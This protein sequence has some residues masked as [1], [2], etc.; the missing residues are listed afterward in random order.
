MFYMHLLGTFRVC[1]LCNKK[2][3]EKRNLNLQVVHFIG[4]KIK[5]KYLRI[6]VF[7]L[8]AREKGKL[9]QQK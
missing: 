9:G 7:S 3:K 2:K 5:G 6:T 8:R 1:W 4:L